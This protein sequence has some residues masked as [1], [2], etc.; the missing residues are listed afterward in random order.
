MTLA[1]TRLPTEARQLEIVHA[2]LA[3]TAE[4]SPDAITTQAIAQH[5]GLTQGL[6]AA[7]VAD[8]APAALRGS[9]FG[10]FNEQGQWVPRDPEGVQP[11]EPS[12]QES[13]ND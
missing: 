1:K 3:L 13:S 7:L 4:N 10:A 8:V 2:V 11:W 12:T 6:L 9:A 5:M